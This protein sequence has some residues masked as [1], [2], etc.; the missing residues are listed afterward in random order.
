MYIER[1]ISSSK[2]VWSSTFPSFSSLPLSPS[3]SPLS[4]SSPVPLLHSLYFLLLWITLSHK[5]NLNTEVFYVGLFIFRKHFTLECLSFRSGCKHKLPTQNKSIWEQAEN[6]HHA[7]LSPHCDILTH[8]LDFYRRP[9]LSS[10]LLWGNRHP[11]ASPVIAQHF[12][13]APQHLWM[14]AVWQM[15]LRLW[16]LWSRLLSETSW[17]IP[18]AVRTPLR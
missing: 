11:V 9:L 4:F 8:G 6:Q 5:C 2:T 7:F 3:H 12:V 14:W 10:Q 16:H 17:Q 18:V 1:Y 15:K 13:D